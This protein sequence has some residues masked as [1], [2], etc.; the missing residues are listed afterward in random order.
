MSCSRDV[1]RRGRGGGRG[2]RYKRC[3]QE[4]RWK[5]EWRLRGNCRGS[6][7]R[8]HG[9]KEGG[10]RG[11]RRERVVGAKGVLRGGASARDLH[12]A[13]RVRRWGVTRGDGEGVLGAG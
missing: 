13:W 4:G 6:A 8:S 3:V 5:G 11:R 12:L 2:G 1:T 7:T 10:V 9:E